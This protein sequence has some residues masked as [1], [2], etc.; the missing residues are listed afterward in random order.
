[1]LCIL[2]HLVDT[3]EMFTVQQAS[4]NYSAQFCPLNILNRRIFQQFFSL[5]E[6]NITRSRFI[7]LLHS[8]IMGQRG[9]KRVVVSGF[10][11]VILNLMQLCTFAGLK[12]S[13]YDQRWGDFEDWIR[14]RMI[15]DLFRWPDLILETEIVCYA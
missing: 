15:Q 13:R 14:M 8:L 3:L 7:Q 9:M 6:S 11:N 10:C 5:H 2:E 1:M 4:P 12:Y